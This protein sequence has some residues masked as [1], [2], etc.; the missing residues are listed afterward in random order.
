MT[1]KTILFLAANPRNM[2][3]LRLDEEMRDIREALKREHHG[4]RFVMERREA[5]RPSDLQQVI[6]EV[7][8]QIVHFSGHGKGEAG[9][10]FEDKAGRVQCIQSAALAGLFKLF[11]RYIE[12]VVLNACYSEEQAEAIVAHINYTI[13]MNQEIGNRAAI[14]FSTSFYS[15]LAAGN[16]IELAYE[17]GL[18]SIQLEGIPEHLTPVLKKKPGLDET[19]AQKLWAEAKPDDESKP[20]LGDR[21]AKKSSADKSARKG[22]QQTGASIQGITIT[23]GD[24]SS[25]NLGNTTQ[26]N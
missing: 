17:F 2:K 5:V 21:D 6:R 20:H 22:N 4:D 25:F 23:G 24:G 3:S 1:P 13:G 10:V 8:P 11:S 15:A 9:L 16:A 7:Q 12:C 14:A 26:N 18:N 19:A